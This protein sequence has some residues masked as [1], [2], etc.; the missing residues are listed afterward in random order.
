MPQRPVSEVICKKSFVQVPATTTV[1]QVAH[2]MK[3]RRTSA[4]LV[5]NSR[6]TLLGICTERDMVVRVLA[7]DQPPEST[8]VADVMTR[9]PVTIRPDQPFGHAL[10]RMYEGGFR[11]V[12]VVD[13]FGRALGLVCARDALDLDALQLEED[14]VRREEITVI[15]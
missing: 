5:T 8:V 4:V 2:L 7:V 9:N 1:R 13:E 6:H 10:H 3:D 14:L 12:P 11:H 15:L